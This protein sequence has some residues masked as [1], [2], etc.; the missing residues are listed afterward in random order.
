MELT[1]FLEATS[2]KPRTWKTRVGELSPYTRISHVHVPSASGPDSMGFSW[3]L[4]LI[5]VRSNTLLLSRFSFKKSQVS[6]AEQAIL[7]EQLDSDLERLGK[8]DDD[9][10]RAL[11]LS[12]SLVAI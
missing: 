1:W 12:R 2:A 10:A 8:I 3:T 9:L 11:Q 5:P 4:T 6:E 7:S